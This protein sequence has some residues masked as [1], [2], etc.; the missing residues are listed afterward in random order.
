[1]KSSEELFITALDVKACDA[2]CCCS[3]R[4]SAMEIPSYGNTINMT[5]HEHSVR[6]Q[7]KLCLCAGNMSEALKDAEAA[8][9]LDT[10]NPVWK[11][12]TSLMSR[13]R[14]TTPGGAHRRIGELSHEMCVDSPRESWAY[15]MSYN[16]VNHND[17][18]ESENARFHHRTAPSI[19]AP[20]LYCAEWVVIYRFILLV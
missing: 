14:V 19:L 10:R 5:V 13:T 9:V 2:Y 12:I 3:Q 7:R 6:L 18:Q 8:V 17:P 11:D 1:M 16:V 4:R 20:R 15:I